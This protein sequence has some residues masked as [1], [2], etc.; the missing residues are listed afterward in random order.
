MVSR[1]PRNWAGPTFSGPGFPAT[2]VRPLPVSEPE[3]SCLVCRT[4]PPDPSPGRERCARHAHVKWSARRPCP[5]CVGSCRR[6]GLGKD[7]VDAGTAS[8]TFLVAVAMRDREQVVQV[9]GGERFRG[10]S[11][12]LVPNGG[13]RQRHQ[14]TFRVTIFRAGLRPSTPA[15]PLR[16]PPLRGPL[17][18]VAKTRP[19][20]PPAGY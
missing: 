3:S 5:D 19:A 10:S 4:T 13:Q 14:T 15:I 2:P 1:P 17:P 20:P 8:G 7:G 12:G 6:R 9:H 16:S 11:N 18:P